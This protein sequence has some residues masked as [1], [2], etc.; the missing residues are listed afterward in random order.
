MANILP[1]M[2]ESAACESS[3]ALC[4]NA[5]TPAT[6]WDSNT[7]VT[8]CQHIIESTLAG[9][10]RPRRALRRDGARPQGRVVRAAGL[11]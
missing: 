10:G 3:S 8:L 1:T 7:A 9:I 11:A 2:Y 5:G 6:R 4:A